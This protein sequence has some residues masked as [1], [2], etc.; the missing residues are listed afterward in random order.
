MDWRTIGVIGGMGPAATADF[1]RL[2][3]EGA[4]ASQDG[5]HPRVIIDS[6]PRI[7]ARTAALAG[8]GPS[9]GPML[10]QSAQQLVAMG[11]EVLAMPCNAA[12]AWV[13]D[14]RRVT[15]AKF[16]DIVDSALAAAMMYKPR[17]IGIIAI[18]A[19]INARLYNRAV[20]PLLVADRVYV[21]A[22]VDRVKGG[23]TGVEVAAAMSSIAAGLVSQGADVI[24]AA[25]TEV[26]LVLQA[27]AVT[28]PFIDSTAALAAATLAAARID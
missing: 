14:V 21:Q 9:P 17:S 4:N 1:M 3:V 11:A 22:L 2:L 16:V 12:H 5:D 20:V 18:G 6:N 10:A 13:S 8:T 7:P 15:G 26:P 28:V 25:C 19:T 24:I 27:T 23:D